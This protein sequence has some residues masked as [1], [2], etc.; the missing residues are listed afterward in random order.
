[1][2]RSFG[3]RRSIRL[4]DFDYS[5]EGWYFVTLATRFR[6]PFFRDP[7]LLRIAEENYLAL[8]QQY[9]T[10]ATNAWA[11]MPDHMHF[12]IHLDPPR[13]REGAAGG[14][15]EGAGVKAHVRSRVRAQL[16]CALTSPSTGESPSPPIGISLAVDRLRPTLGQVVRSF[17][18]RVTRRAHQSGEV[19]FRWQRN[20]YERVIR[21][22]EELLAVR[23]YI[24]LNP[25]VDRLQSTLE[26]KESRT[27]GL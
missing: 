25:D 16:N 17:K 10:L 11:V 15:V 27:H 6:H 4:Q 23:E 1:M 5:G 14:G 18:A 7:L 9:P 22:E 8:P 13:D 19:G 20:Y 21:N 12:L 24:L 26:T 2:V 3:N